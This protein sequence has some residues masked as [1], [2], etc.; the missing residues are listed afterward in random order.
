MPPARHA[1]TACALALAL[2][3]LAAA[4]S[5][6]GKPKVRFH[7][8]WASYPSARYAAMSAAQCRKELVRRKIAFEPVRRAPGVLAPVRLMQGVGGVLYRTALPAH[9]RAENPY[10]VFDCRLALALSD[11]SKILRVHDIDEV[12]MFSAWRPPSRMWPE[13]KLATRHPGGLAIDPYRFVKER[14][15]DDPAERWLDV[16]RDFAGRRGA[17][18]CGE[19]AGAVGK[20]GAA[21]RRARGPAADAATRELRSIVCE[22]ADQH[23][24]T[25]I[26]T[27]N[28]DRAH[29]N[30]LHLEVTP[31]VQWHLLR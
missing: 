14:A 21:G 26:L 28:Y 8:D 20:R 19:G 16:E 31:D 6:E 30:H 25:S 5:A 15:P 24:F 22:A 29:R 23:I 11:F 12:L 1:I 7:Q 18:V 10:D 2:A 17:P 27:P 3:P 9:R 4:P 13:G